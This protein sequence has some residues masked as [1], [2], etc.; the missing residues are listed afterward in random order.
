MELL[1]DENLRFFF[2]SR[3]RFNGI[4]PV[5]S[6]NMKSGVKLSFLQTPWGRLL[7]TS[8][9]YLPYASKRLLYAGS[10]LLEVSCIFNHLRLRVIGF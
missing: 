2:F 6:R 5:F 9:I 7:D 1:W 4:L 10:C 8:R 3:G